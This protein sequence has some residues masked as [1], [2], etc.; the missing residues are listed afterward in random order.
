MALG[1]VVILSWCST[2]SNEIRFCFT[3]KGFPSDHSEPMFCGN[4]IVIERW[5][6]PN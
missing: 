4:E 5:L 2:S 6:S 3:D 1:G